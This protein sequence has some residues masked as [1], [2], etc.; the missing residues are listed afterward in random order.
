MAFKQTRMRR[1]EGKPVFTKMKKVPVLVKQSSQMI[2]RRWSIWLV[3]PA[4]RK[5]AGTSF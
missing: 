5:N 3:Q 1:F 4:S 2:R